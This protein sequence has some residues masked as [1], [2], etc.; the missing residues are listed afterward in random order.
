VPS[1][2]EHRP[3]APK[4]TILLA[5]DEPQLRELGETILG[6]A[7]YKVVVA[8]TSDALRSLVRE[9]P[10]SVDLLLTDVIMPGLGG[11]ELV[12]MAK[13]RWPGIRVLYVSGYRREQIKG[14]DPQVPFLEKPF[15]PGEL[16]QKIAELL[17][18]LSC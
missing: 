5:E 16:L 11:L 12:G 17:E 6:R 1:T 14:L 8:A 10:G 2:T 3:L 13:A 18:D 15:T 4:A 7:G 9:Y